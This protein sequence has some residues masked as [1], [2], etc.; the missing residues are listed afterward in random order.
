MTEVTQVA[1]RNGCSRMEVDL[2]PVADFG[3]ENSKSS[4]KSKPLSNTDQIAKT[5]REC[6]R[7]FVEMFSSIQSSTVVLFPTESE[8]ATARNLW[9]P[10][11]RGE[12]L[13]MDIPKVKGFSK[14]NSRRFSLEEQKSALLSDDGV[15]IP[16]GTLVLIIAGPRAKDWKSIV[17]INNKLDDNTV[18]ILL[19]SRA[20]A[21]T[22]LSNQN[23]VDAFNPLNWIEDNYEN[24]FHYAPPFVKDDGILKGRDI[25]LYHQHNE[26]WSLLEREKKSGLMGIGNAGSFKTLWEG[27]N[28]PSSEIILNCLM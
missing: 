15:Y 8:A 10:L 22:E 25:L 24:V 11:F 3:I 21:T 16:E 26:K 27:E 1:L 7:L 9:S 13:A 20:A 19:N 28:R 5:N 2:P 4:G 23:S 18:V 17:R 12:I 6:A 14:L